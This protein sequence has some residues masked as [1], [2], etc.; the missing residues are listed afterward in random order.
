MVFKDLE[1]G[2]YPIDVHPIGK[3]Q[4]VIEQ[5]YVRGFTGKEQKKDALKEIRNRANRLC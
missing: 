2:I 1:F 5:Q 3:V 4:M